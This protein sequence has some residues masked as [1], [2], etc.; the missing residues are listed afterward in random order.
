MKRISFKELSTGIKLL[1]SPDEEVQQLGIELLRIYNINAF[2]GFN[3]T[4]FR[5]VFDEGSNIYVYEGG[6]LIRSDGIWTDNL[7][8]F[9]T[10]WIKESLSLHEKILMLL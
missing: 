5:L 1:Q 10:K 2:P 7:Q 4:L 6:I 8:Q 3:N 9:Y